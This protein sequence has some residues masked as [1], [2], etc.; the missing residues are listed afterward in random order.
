MD[1]SKQ[2][3]AQHSQPQAT[4]ATQESKAGQTNTDETG[5]AGRH[6]S[7]TDFQ[8]NT[9]RKPNRPT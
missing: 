8:Q 1:D 6:L 7:R 3:Q 2:Q 9:L 4:K 5:P